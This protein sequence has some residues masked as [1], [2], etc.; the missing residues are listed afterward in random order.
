MKIRSLL[1]GSVAAAGLST[2]AF[3]ADLGVMTSLDVC[4]ALGI[5]GL[6]ISSDNNCLAI[7]GSVEYEFRW[8]DYQDS[9]AYAAGFDGYDPFKVDAPGADPGWCIRLV[10]E[11]HR[12][13][14]VHR[15]CRL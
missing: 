8:G 1:L 13:A 10:L 3:A 7:T 9:F 15:D 4:D 14:D 11:V 6:T 5:S 12:Q 2:G